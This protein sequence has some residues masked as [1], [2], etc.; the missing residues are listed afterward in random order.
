MRLSVE[1][2][3]ARQVPAAATSDAYISALYLGFLGRQADPSDLAFWDGRLGVGES[4]AQVASEVVA[5]PEF[6][7]RE[8]QILY[9][10]YL[11]RPLDTVGLQT[12][13]GVLRGGGSI[14]QVKAGILGSDEFFADKGNS[15]ANLLSAVYQSQLGRALDAVGQNFW[16]PRLVGGALTRPAAV[17]QILASAEANRVKVTGVYQEIL[18]RGLDSAGAAYWG[19]VLGGGQTLEAVFSGVAG[20][21]EFVNSLAASVARSNQNDPNLAADQFFLQGG[22]FAAIVSAVEQLDLNFPTNRNI[23]T[24]V[25]SVPAVPTFPVG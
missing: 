10:V 6:Q 21:D 9:Q 11:G 13:E 23:N 8:L 12:W 16:T 14:E 25:T 15:I 1:Q 20:S 3:E 2:L 24:L 18:A 4:R 5:S 19:G 22:R 7:G 17:A